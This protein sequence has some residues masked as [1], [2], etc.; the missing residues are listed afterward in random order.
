MP[1]TIDPERGFFVKVDKKMIDEAYE[2][3]FSGLKNYEIAAA[4]NISSS[5]FYLK[6]R[7]SPDLRS[8]VEK[9]RSLAVRNVTS[10]LYDLAINGNV[11]AIDVYLG[12]IRRHM[13]IHYSEKTAKIL[14]SKEKSP[15][16]KIEALLEDHVNGY[17]SIDIV[18][19]MTKILDTL[20]VARN[21]AELDRKVSALS[22]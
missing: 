16:E 3:A 14:K 4:L 9:A 7:E 19:S 18:Q 5:T 8:A 13:P 2:L 15:E 22:K 12:N 6:C 11:K 20:Y 1:K 10:K 21:V 17:I